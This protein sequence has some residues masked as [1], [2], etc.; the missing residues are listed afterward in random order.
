MRHPG[1]GL[2]RNE[3]PKLSGK[4][5]TVTAGTR[6]Q[7]TRAGPHANRARDLED[8]ELFRSGCS[9]R[10][11]SLWFFCVD[12]HQHAG[13]WRTPE[14][15]FLIADG[16]TH[17]CVCP[18]AS[19]L[20][21]AHSI[22]ASRRSR[23]SPLTS[24]PERL[25]TTI[26]QSRSAARFRAWH[27]WQ[28]SQS[29]PHLQTDPPDVNPSLVTNELASVTRGNSKDFGATFDDGPGRPNM[30]TCHAKRSVVFHLS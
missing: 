9:E 6:P 7:T 29:A 11:M 3:P 23:R 20:G 22:R 30:P 1:S 17:W 2:E 21:R 18:P 19:A 10:A 14:V 5:C 12:A 26:A 28:R 24:V 13:T 27:T 8:G 25:R 15:N 16:T 4:H